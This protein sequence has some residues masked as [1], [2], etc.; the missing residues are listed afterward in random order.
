[1]IDVINDFEFEDGAKLFK[2][3]SQMARKL[4]ALR[5]KAENETSLPGN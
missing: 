4:A 3:A 1:L 5:E 2:N